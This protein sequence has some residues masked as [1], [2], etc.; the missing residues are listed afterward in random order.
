[1]LSRFLNRTAPDVNVKKQEPKRER[2]HVSYSDFVKKTKSNELTDII[3]NPR[4]SI[5]VY[6]TTEDEF[7]DA[8]IYD[9]PELW[10]V[11]SESDA[12]VV[13][14]VSSP[15]NPL[16]FVSV[17]IML[18]FLLII[19]RSILGGVGGG[20]S[21]ANPFAQFTQQFAI[22]QDVSARFSDVEGIDG[23]KGELIEIV[24]FLK[25]PTRFHLNGARVPKGAILSGVPGCGKTLLARAIAGESNVP[26]INVSGSAFVEMF[27]GV[28]ASR[29]RS[30]FDLAKQHEPCIIFIDEID[31]IGK[32]R[33]FGAF[34]G[35]DEREGTLNQLLTE[36]DGFEETSGI[37]VLAATNR[38]DTLDDALLRP[39]RFDRK[40]EVALPNKD[41]R[42]RILDVHAKNKRLHR[43]VDL[44]EIA[45]MT[46]G[47]SGADLANL[48]NECAIRAVQ[49]N[50]GL[51]TR[52]L[53]EDCYQRITVGSKSET[54]MHTE[55]REIVAFHEAGHAIMGALCP[56]YDVL[57]KVS[58]I[59]RGDAGGVTFFEPREEV[60]LHSRDYYLDGLRVALGG[61]AAEEVVFGPNKITTGAS[62][63]L[64]AVYAT[65]RAML[66][67]WNFG[68]MHFD[69]ENMSDATKRELDVQVDALVQGLYAETAD[70]LRM[71]RAQLELLKHKLV[72][73]EIV[74]GQ[75]VYDTMREATRCDLNK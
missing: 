45:G 55:M 1:M 51:I 16:E 67:D 13:V 29:V 75:Y 37:I 60:A 39:G 2:H 22:E 12:D 23:A 70:T 62:G 68:T 26:F 4:T 47:F 65:A 20:Q 17:G 10:R 14:D 40:I 59:P 31:A 48:L 7:G 63:D 53:V 58:I 74:D 46:T 44:K 36:M 52:T 34:G 41:G 61:R 30:L 25:D 73:E 57:R 28:G 72:E 54:V 18:F 35:N 50:D 24:E 66:T 32:K 49:I 33:G 3:V 64:R 27:V 38:V 11:L 8:Q 19:I 9:N 21:G 15:P 43:D 6:K 71:H 5:A 56:S 69:N 42:A